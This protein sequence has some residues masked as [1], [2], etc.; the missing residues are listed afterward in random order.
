[1]GRSTIAILAE[2]KNNVIDLQKWIV[3]KEYVLS[4]LPR[5]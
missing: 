2:V 5:M 1:M 4:T 3:V